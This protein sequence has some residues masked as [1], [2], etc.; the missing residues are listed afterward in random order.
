[1]SVDTVSDETAFYPYMWVDG[2]DECVEL[3]AAANFRCT[4]ASYGGVGCPSGS[5]T[6]PSDG[7]YRVVVQSG[8]SCV[9][10]EV[11]YTIDVRT[12]P[13]EL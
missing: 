2:P 1:M 10:E 12:D 5:F 7:S 11:S 9:S 13:S 3:Y 6:A 4:Y 8:G